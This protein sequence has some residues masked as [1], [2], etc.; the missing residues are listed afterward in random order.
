MELAIASDTPAEQGA[1]LKQAAQMIEEFY[2]MD[3]IL[4][5]TA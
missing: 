1:I 4:P 5:E 3:G 2:G